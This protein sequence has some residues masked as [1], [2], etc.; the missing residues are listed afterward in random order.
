MT[1]YRALLVDDERLARRRLAKLLGR[2]PEIEV[3]AEA[4]DVAGAVTELQADPSLNL[5]FLDIQMPGGSGFELFSRTRVQASVVFV[6]AF[7]EHALRAF[8]VNALDYLL[9]PVDPAHLQRAVARLPPPGKAATRPPLDDRI[10]LPLGTG[11][12]FVE[13]EDIA[14]IRA[15]GDYSEV[16]LRSGER[17]LVRVTMRQWE[18][19]LS[20]ERFSRVHRSVIVGVHAVRRLGAGAG[21]SYLVEVEGVNEPLPVSRSQ[22]RAVRQ[23]LTAEPGR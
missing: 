9:K 18:Q 10:C 3:A 2:H 13:P 16:C 15:E 11:A 22:F 14:C 7:D 17:E 23:R 5:V 6:T 1:A 8:E 12:R 20:A 4:E 19:Q 21:S